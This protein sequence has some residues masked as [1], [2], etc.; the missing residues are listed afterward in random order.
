MGEHF[1]KLLSY[2][3]SAVWSG[4][5]YK[6]LRQTTF[7]Q[8]CLQGTGFLSVL[9][10]DKILSLSCFE[11]GTLKMAPRLWYGGSCTSAKVFPLL[12]V[13]TAQR[14]NKLL[15]C[16]IF[17]ISVITSMLPLLF[18][19]YNITHTHTAEVVKPLWN[20]GVGQVL[21][22]LKPRGTGLA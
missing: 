8:D 10:F 3:G 15:C 9:V 13:L 4:S 21:E 17:Y 19:R 22:E 16:E 18:Y 2:T 1:K 14:R 20:V 6:G 11:S 12:Q 7:G 5:Q